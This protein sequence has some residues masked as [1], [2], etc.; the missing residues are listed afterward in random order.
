MQLVKQE[1]VQSFDEEAWKKSL[2]E[3][4]GRW[5]VAKIDLREIGLTGM[6]WINLAQDREQCKALVNAELNCRVP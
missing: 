2:E 6:N 3:P 1:C 5:E 4:T